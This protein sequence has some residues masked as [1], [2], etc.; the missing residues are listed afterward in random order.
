MKSVARLDPFDLNVFLSQHW[1]QQPCLIGNWLRPGPLALD[2][3]L[4]LADQ[5]DLPSRLV[6]GNH[7]AENWALT[8]GPLDELP[9]ASRDWT[10][11]VQEVDKASPE[12]ADILTHFRFLPDWMIDDVMIS[13]AVDGGSVGAHVDAYDV[14][15]VQ[16]AG[17]RRW[18]LAEHFDDQTDERFELAL[19]KR[20]QPEVE[21]MVE[22]GEVLYLPPGFAHHGI[23][24]G[25]CQTWSV[26]MRTPSGPELL[27]HLAERQAGSSGNVRRLGM[28]R[29]DRDLPSRI[30]AEI[31]DDIRRLLQECLQ[32]DDRQLADLAGR[33]LTS[34]RT[35]PTDEE[36]AALDQV[37]KSLA[38]GQSL[39]LSPAARLALTED[40]DETVLY[41]NGERI[42]CSSGMACQLA[43][44]RS[45]TPDWLD[46]PDAME[47]LLEAEAI[48]PIT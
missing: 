1:Q 47:Q 36:S 12:V 25:N 44:T 21:L 8:H 20:W 7:A 26:G 16:A 2:E 41:V 17:R 18:Q 15:L 22:P 46:H 13:Q 38:D 11:L 33:F 40:G 34:W 6:T 4:D 3:L 31:L 42:V 43:R 48:A 30:H 32:L 24:D 28:Q 45:L 14:F 23:A 39:A 27:F 37:R 19:L 9:M 29:P 10:V 5:H 35:W